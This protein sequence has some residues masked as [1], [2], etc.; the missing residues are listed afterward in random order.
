MESEMKYCQSCGMPMTDA[1]MFGTNA[2]GS[3]NEDY[4]SYCYQSGK[5]TSD[6]SMEQM[7]EF[8]VPY[9]MKNSPEM[10]EDKAR[11]LL[12]EMYPQLRRWKK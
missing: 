12:G 3:P 5:F 10:S 2:D 8:C 11:Q 1:G 4:C 6:M 9:V 7:I